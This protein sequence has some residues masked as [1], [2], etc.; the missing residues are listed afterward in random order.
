MLPSPLSIPSSSLMAGKTLT[1][2]APIVQLRPLP[3]PSNR[4]THTSSFA[5]SRTFSTPRT[6]KNWLYPNRTPST[7]IPQSLKHGLSTPTF[8]SDLLNP[9]NTTS[10]FPLN[11]YAS[12]FKT[13]SRQARSQKTKSKSSNPA[14]SVGIYDYPH[15]YAISALPT[16]NNVAAASFRERGTWEASVPTVAT[17]NKFPNRTRYQGNRNEVNDWERRTFKARGELEQNGNRVSDNIANCDL[18]TKRLP[19]DN[20]ASLAF[21]MKGRTGTLDG[22][23][24]GGLGDISSVYCPGEFFDPSKGS[25]HVKDGARASAVFRQV[26]VRPATDIEMVVQKYIK[27]KMRPSSTPNATRNKNM[28]LDSVE[29]GYERDQLVSFRPRSYTQDVSRAFEGERNLRMRKSS[30]VRSM[31][32]NEM[33]SPQ[34][35]PNFAQSTQLFTSSF[36]GSHAQMKT[37]KS[38]KTG[39][40]YTKAMMKRGPTSV[41]VV[42]KHDDAVML[43]RTLREAE[44]QLG[45]DWRPVTTD[46]ND[47]N[48]LGH[49]FNS[50]SDRFRKSFKEIEEDKRRQAEKDDDKKVVII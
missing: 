3:P 14:P 34:Q 38:R 27:G 31:N 48:G 40:V 36:E 6:A 20:F 26:S 5:N 28:S 21:T 46:I 29:S 42:P 30:S 39:E 17:V 15:M 11:N 50:A 49:V 13:K 24:V 7:D 8:T 47:K 16:S 43:G 41:T 44:L 33:S 37:F 2:A 32:I 25:V 1:K 12:A 45:W 35:R 10:S 4:G 18:N 19:D 23:N 9:N 22:K